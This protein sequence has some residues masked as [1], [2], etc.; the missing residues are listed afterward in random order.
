MLW[1][2]TR[3]LIVPIRCGLL[4]SQNLLEHSGANQTKKVWNQFQL[5]KY[6]IWQKN[7]FTLSGI[8]HCI[9]YHIIIIYYKCISQNS[10]RRSYFLG[11][12]VQPAS[13]MKSE[14]ESAKKWV[15]GSK[16]SWNKHL[17]ILKIIRS[18]VHQSYLW[19]EEWRR[20]WS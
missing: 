2:V 13:E 16:A 3:F 9:N 7:S 17:H 18:S 10:S 6:Q 11:F 12:F 5:F 4:F 1:F 15:H 20:S 19:K 14:L 8:K